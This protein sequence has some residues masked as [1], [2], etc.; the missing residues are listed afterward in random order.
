[1]KTKTIRCNYADADQITT[2]ALVAS[3]LA[4]FRITT[5][6]IIN[7]GLL[8]MSNQPTDESTSCF[9]EQAINSN[10]PVSH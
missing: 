2:L 1:M 3:G 5:A 6:D 4:Q 10:K 9:I 8:K 7:Y